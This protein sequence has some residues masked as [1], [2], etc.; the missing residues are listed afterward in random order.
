[1]SFLLIL[2]VG[3]AL[4][5][6]QPAHVLEDQSVK[7]KVRFFLL[8]IYFKVMIFVELISVSYPSFSD[9]R[10]VGFALPQKISSLNKLVL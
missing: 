9:N 10:Q 8:H 2:F 1:M 6:E 3:P 5:A 4:S 7:V